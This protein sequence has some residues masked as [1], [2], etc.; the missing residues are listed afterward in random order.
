MGNDFEPC[1]TPLPGA[2]ERDPADMAF[3]ERRGM[4]QLAMQKYMIGIDMSWLTK[5]NTAK[6]IVDF[7]DERVART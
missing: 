5:G 3:E 4:V 1:V 7:T 2:A 6:A